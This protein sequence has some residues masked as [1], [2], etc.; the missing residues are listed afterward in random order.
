MVQQNEST[1]SEIGVINPPIEI[2][3]IIDTTAD[4]VSRMGTDFVNRIR[5]NEENNTKF[6]FLNTGDPYHAYYQQKVKECKDGKP[7]KTKEDSKRTTLKSTINN[8]QQLKIID[9]PPLKD[10]PSELTF[11]VDAPTINLDELDTLKLTATFVARNGRSFLDNLLSR[12]S[13][14][15]QFDFLK[16]QHSYYP[17]FTKLVSQYSKVFLPK[18]SMINE[19]NDMSISVRKIN[20]NIAYRV[21][22]CKY[23]KCQQ[24]KEMANAERQ[25]ILYSQIDWHSFV[26]VEVVDYKSTE[27]GNFPPPTTPEE[28]GNRVLE[29]S[30]FSESNYQLGS[31]D[32]EVEPVKQSIPD[33]PQISVDS[34]FNDDHLMPP[35]A[36][37]G[38]ESIVRHNYDPKASKQNMS[39]QNLNFISPLTQQKMTSNDV[40]DH[41]RYGLLDPS[42]INNRER[43]RMADKHQAAAIL[44]TGM[45]VSSNLKRLAERRTDIFGYGSEEA[46]I[47]RKIGE[48]TSSKPKQEERITWDGHAS[49]I[50]SVSQRARKDITIEDQIK[51]IHRSQGL[52]HDEDK[53]KI[54]PKKV[55]KMNISEPP[56][57]NIKMSESV[58]IQ[59]VMRPKPEQ[60][61]SQYMPP[62][63][64]INIPMIQLP[65]P[66]PMHMIRPMPMMNP[67]PMPPFHP[68]GMPMR[69]EQMFMRPKRPKDDHFIPEG[70]YS[71]LNPDDITVKIQIPV[72]SDKTDWKLDGRTLENVFPI[73]A[74]ITDV[75]NFICEQTKLPNGKQK[76]QIGGLFAKDMNSLAHY[77]IKSNDIF[78]LLIKER[79]GR[80]R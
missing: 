26:V 44:A 76:I 3:N 33:T 54:G 38:P 53:E 19:I 79:G 17:Y 65:P 1:N 52:V 5:K 31:L 75:K 4:Y 42:W 69:H 29:E 46:Q 67:H 78:I 68:M 40:S 2:R 48:D 47:G 13:R 18:R 27:Y 74:S 64:G 72:V 15:S 22:W 66:Q 73:M 57:E 55:D 61:K 28:V 11:I 24:E 36:V 59:H 77:N 32:N 63:P 34:N 20:E 10:P 23:R 58:K 14:N 60:M 21:R 7:E 30:R 71:A 70:E 6:N 49:S 51:I 12:E 45:N 9:E 62:G 80:K 25:R 16:P 37:P 8:M 35:P 50:E 39:D 56:S 41:M 43:E